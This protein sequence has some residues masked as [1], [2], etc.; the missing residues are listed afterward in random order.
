PVAA[1]LLGDQHG[2]RR[3]DALSHLGVRQE[4]RYASVGADREE[5]VRI[6]QGLRGRR[7]LSKGEAG[8]DRKADHETRRGLEELPAVDARARAHA[9]LPSSAARWTA[10]RM[11]W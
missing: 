10:A 5:R 2:Q 9:F 6:G 3:P 7:G 11:C 1:E 8:S 4:N